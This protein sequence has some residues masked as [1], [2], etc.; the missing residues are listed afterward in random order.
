[1]IIANRMNFGC[2]HQ[3][4]SDDGQMRIELYRMYTVNL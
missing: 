3:L 4:R 2:L 1:M